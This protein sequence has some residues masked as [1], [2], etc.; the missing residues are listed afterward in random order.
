VQGRIAPVDRLIT[1]YFALPTRIRLDD[2]GVHSKAFAFDQACV[3]AATQHFIE[4]PAKQIAVPNRA[5]EVGEVMAQ[6]AQIKT[7][8]NAVQKVIG[9]DVIFEIERVKQPFL[10]TR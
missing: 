10:S 4:Q 8:I 2:A 9:W 3:H 5:I 7:L 6:I 1:R